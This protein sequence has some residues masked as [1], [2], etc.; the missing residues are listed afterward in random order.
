MASSYGPD[1]CVMG[2][3]ALVLHDILSRPG[4]AM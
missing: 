3:V 2:G 4:L 1:A